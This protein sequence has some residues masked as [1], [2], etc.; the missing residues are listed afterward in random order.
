ME[1]KIS[2]T[3]TKLGHQIPSINLPAILTCRH[4]APCAKHNC[5]ATRGNWL[6]PNV[7]ASLQNNLALF[8]HNSNEYF[9]SIIR[10]LNGLTLYRY[11]RWHSSGDIVNKDY[12]MGMIKVAKKCKNT[13]FLCFT[14][15][16]EIVNEYLEEGKLPKNLK[17]IFSAWDK[18]FKVPNPHN[19]SVAYVEFRKPEKTPEIPEGAIECVGNCEACVGCW[20]LKDGANVIFHEH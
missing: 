9:N 18:E 17:I 7:K 15:K 19:L 16:F 13:K 5:Y 1:V 11:V 8:V 12:L 20:G 4:D 10:Q 14:K 6:Y 2:T 3:N